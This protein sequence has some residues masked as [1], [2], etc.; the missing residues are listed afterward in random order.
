MDL[1]SCPETLFWAALSL[2]RGPLGSRC[3]FVEP[4]LGVQEEKLQ[5]LLLLRHQL[6]DTNPQ[7]R[8]SRQYAA[9]AG[10][11]D[12]E[13]KSLSTTGEARDLGKFEMKGVDLQGLRGKGRHVR[14]FLRDG[15]LSWGPRGQEKGKR[16]GWRE[17]S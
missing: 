8:G 13:L 7:G 1:S 15:G 9:Q 4:G 12:A 14:T 10:R 17:T 3:V 6:M 2:L 5:P 16:K 11:L